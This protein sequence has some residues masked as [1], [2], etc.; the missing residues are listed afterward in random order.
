MHTPACDPPRGM[1]PKGPSDAA[2]Q[3]TSSRGRP[4]CLERSTVGL[5]ACR[6]RVLTASSTSRPPST[7]AY[8][9]IETAK[10]RSGLALRACQL[11]LPMAPITCFFS[12]S[13]NGPS[14]RSRGD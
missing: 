8:W 6:T 11:S 5:R 12:S 14:G 4:R 13:V 3:T 2:R 7:M 1:A 10:D 9:H